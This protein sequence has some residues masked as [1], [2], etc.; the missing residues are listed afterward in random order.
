MR[1]LTDYGALHTLRLIGQPPILLTDALFNAPVTPYS[2]VGD[3]AGRRA[4]S[5]PQDALRV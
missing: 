5:S 3:N 4:A 1:L 2:V